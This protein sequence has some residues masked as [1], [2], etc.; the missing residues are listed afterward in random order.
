MD[1]GT[2][3]RH[4]AAADRHVAEGERH[5]ARQRELIAEL[6]RNG[7]AS[8]DARGL[9][10]TLEDMQTSHVAHQDRLRRELKAGTE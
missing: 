4:L 9:L 3:L 7:H 8:A 1:R 6:E 2:V 10:A 5:I